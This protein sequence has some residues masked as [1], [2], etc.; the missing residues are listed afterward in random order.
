ML[1]EFRVTRYKSGGVAGTEKDGLNGVAGLVCG[2]ELEPPM[3]AS[4]CL[5]FGDVTGGAAIGAILWP[6]SRDGV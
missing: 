5:E 1:G 2:R 6:G 3:K 4:F